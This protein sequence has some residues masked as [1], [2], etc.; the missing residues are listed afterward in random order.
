MA[1]T[2][3]QPDG[4]MTGAKSL[5]TP[6][7]AAIAGIIFSVLMTTSSILIKLS[8]PNDPSQAGDWLTNSTLKDMVVFALNLIPFAGIAFLWFIGVIRDR[9]GEREDRFFATV[10]LGSGLLYIA[11][12]FASAA[13][14]IGLLSSFDASSDT[15]LSTG[16]WELSRNASFALVNVYAMKMAAVFSI[17]TATIFLS[18]ATAP[19]W[20]SFLGYAIAL[21]L[22]F[23]SSISG[24]L[25]LLFPAWVL[26]VSIYILAISFRKQAG[27]EVAAPLPSSQ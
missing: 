4:T 5:K 7:A 9:L 11:M 18:T 21:I 1:K 15:L 24:W 13:I 14:A 6:R 16:S 19:R 10:F 25:S 3:E 22:L 26:L 17:S 23:G 12:V 8:L 2:I 20:L 27:D